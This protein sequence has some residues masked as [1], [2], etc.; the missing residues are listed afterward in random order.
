MTMCGAVQ[1][2]SAFQPHSPSC[3]LHFAF[4]GSV[5]K[6]KER[7]SCV[8]A[9]ESCVLEGTAA[10]EDPGAKGAEKEFVVR[11]CGRRTGENMWSSSKQ[12]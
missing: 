10:L 5:C 3:W 11:C 6:H 4:D 9:T 8:T 2:D 7:I 12:G 1:R